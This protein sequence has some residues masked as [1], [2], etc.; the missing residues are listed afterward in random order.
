MKT[1][2][3]LKDLWHAVIVDCKEIIDKNVNDEQ[4][5]KDIKELGF[6]MQK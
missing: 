1:E 4:K 5:K 3:S 6:D 2:L